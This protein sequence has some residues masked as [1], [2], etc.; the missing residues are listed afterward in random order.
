ML[1]DITVVG[2]FVPTFDDRL[3]GLRVLLDA[4][5]WNEKRLLDLEASIGFQDPWYRHF[6][7][8]VQHRNTGDSCR[9]IL[10]VRHMQ[11]AVCIHIKGKGHG[12]ACTVWPDN[13]IFNHA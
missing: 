4:P 1:M 7:A 6:R 8:V 2:N 3:D 12:A 13:R 10:G 11:D 9:G 5:G